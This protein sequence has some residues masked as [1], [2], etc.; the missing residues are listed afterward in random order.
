MKRT[1]ISKPRETEGRS[2]VAQDLLGT[3]RR[4]DANEYKVSSGDVKML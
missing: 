2:A 1:S 4:S 3:G